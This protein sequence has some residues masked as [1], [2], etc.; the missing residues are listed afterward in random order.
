MTNCEFQQTN[1]H[2]GTQ[3]QVIGL[4]E[5][6]CLSKRLQPSHDVVQRLKEGVAVHKPPPI[7]GGKDVVVGPQRQTSL[8]YYAAVA[9]DIGHHIAGRL[10][11]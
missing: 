8:H 3:G 1:L 9:Q 7:R 10:I 5:D 4:E 6:E 11:A 2:S